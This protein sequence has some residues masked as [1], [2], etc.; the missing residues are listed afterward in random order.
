MR[1]IFLSLCTIALFAGLW[2]KQ[3]AQ[4]AAK[5][6]LERIGAKGMLYTVYSVKPDEKNLRLHWLNPSTKKPYHSFS[7][8]AK[9]LRK[10]GEIMLFATNSG[11]FS[12]SYKPLGLHI[13]NGKILSKINKARSG[14]NFALLPNGIFWL[15][16]NKAGIQ[17]TWDYLKNDPNP[18]FA[19]Q[20]GPLLLLKGRIHPKFNAKSTSFKLRSGVGVCKDG[21]VRFAISGAPVN[22]YT[23]ASFFK[24]TLKCDDALYLDGSISAYASKKIDTQLFDFSG[25]WTVSTKGAN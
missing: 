21:M 19:T 13:E 18:T 2:L 11:I 12:P 10:K 22:F 8:V 14:G 23:F 5:P 24:D 4:A 25:I 7:E 17:E 9:Y 3:Q 16:G 6:Q 1:F 20:S 15:K